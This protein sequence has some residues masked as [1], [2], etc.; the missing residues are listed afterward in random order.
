MTGKNNQDLEPRVRRR[1]RN[2]GVRM[3]VTHHNARYAKLRVYWREK[4]R[5]ASD[6]R[7]GKVVPLPTSTSIARKIIRNIVHAEQRV[8]ISP[9]KFSGMR[10]NQR[11]MV[12]QDYIVKVIGNKSCMPDI[13]SCFAV[14][15]YGDLPSA[16]TKLGYLV[17]LGTGQY[18]RLA[19]FFPDCPIVI[20]I[21]IVAKANWNFVWQCFFVYAADTHI[22][23]V[24]QSNFFHSEDLS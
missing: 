10:R 8:E 5:D 4:Q 3:T 21:S 1:E 16:K 12:T 17:L 2:R 24:T 19:F 6:R 20:D 11:T 7:F 9:V 23:D 14:L 13:V 15:C 18:E 22:S